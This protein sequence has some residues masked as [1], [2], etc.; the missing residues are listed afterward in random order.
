MHILEIK[1][2]NLLEEYLQIYKLFTYY[3]KSFKV[4]NICEVNDFSKYTEIVS[5]CFII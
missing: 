3:I 5:K 4:R 1:A 2:F